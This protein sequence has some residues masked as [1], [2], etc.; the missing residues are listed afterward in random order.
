MARPQRQPKVNNLAEAN[1][2]CA[3]Q[4]ADALSHGLKRSDR[5][6]V[7]GRQVKPAVLVTTD[8]AV[9]LNLTQAEVL[10]NPKWWLAN[11]KIDGMDVYVYDKP[12]Y[13]ERHC[14][15]PSDRMFDPDHFSKHIVGAG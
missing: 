3:E 13:T 4:I 15:M 5:A 14:C 7:R 8:L 1:A 12:G 6:T 9:I 10:P 2:A 11:E